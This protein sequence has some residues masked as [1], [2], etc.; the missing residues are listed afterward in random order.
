MAPE[1]LKHVFNGK[2][3]VYLAILAEWSSISLFV[4]LHNISGQRAPVPISTKM[5]SPPERYQRCRR[6][7]GSRK[8]RHGANTMCLPRMENGGSVPTRHGPSSH[9]HACPQELPPS[10]AMPKSVAKK[11]KAVT[12]KKV[13]ATLTRR[14]PSCPHTTA[15][16]QPRRHPT[17]V[18]ILPHFSYDFILQYCDL[19]FPFVSPNNYCVNFHSIRPSSLEKRG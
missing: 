12:N 18:K 9:P 4:F 6:S 5:L 11:R 1:P 10:M 13:A 17:D 16:R 3:L 19:G 8:F 15:I 7:T 14:Q 2:P